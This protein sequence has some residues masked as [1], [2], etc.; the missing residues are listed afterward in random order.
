M[1]RR[2]V[3]ILTGLPAGQEQAAARLYWQAFGAKL[4]KLMGPQVRAERFFTETVSHDRVLAALEGDRLLGIAAF[5]KGGRGF[6]AGGLKEL[7][8]H[9]GPGTLWRAVPLALLERKAPADTLQMDGVCVAAQARGKGVGTAL[10]GALFDFAAARGLN[11]VTLDVIDTN[12]RARALYERLGF[13]AV[14]EQGTG[15]LRPLLGFKSATTMIRE[16]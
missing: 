5:S 9:Y 6:S 13:R 16:V 12:S 15:P 8:Q 2:P 4:G 14:R 10:F 7:W 1:T 11:K 3:R